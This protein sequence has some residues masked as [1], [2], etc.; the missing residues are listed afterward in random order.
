MRKLN[1]KRIILSLLAAFLLCLPVVS[2]AAEITLTT[3]VPSDFTMNVDIQGKGTVIVDGNAYNTDTA[4]TIERLKETKID[5]TPFAGY[6]LKSLHYNGKNVLSKLSSGTLVLPPLEQDSVLKVVFTPDFAGWLP[7]HGG[8]GSSFR[9]NLD[10]EGKG[11]V[12][13]NGKAYSRDTVISIAKNAKPSIKITPFSGY[14]IAA[15][16]YN[17][18]NILSRLDNGILVL[19]YIKNNS[20]LE[21]VFAPCS[22][23]GIPKTG[24]NPTASLCLVSTLML[25]AI[26]TLSLKKKHN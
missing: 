4:L 11:V 26:D 25:L 10:I 2:F 14:E 7:D 18:E 19:P 21:V 22:V 12:T 16:Y 20:V 8:N 13:V 24:D 17:G 1:Y 15:L 6:K 5:I 23:Y 3:T 9:L